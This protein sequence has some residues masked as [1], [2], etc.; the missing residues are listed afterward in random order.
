MKNNI[1]I[2]Y[3][4]SNIQRIILCMNHLKLRHVNDISCGLRK[5]ILYYPKEKKMLNVKII[6]HIRRKNQDCMTRAPTI[7]TI[8]A[9]L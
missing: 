4:K 9:F 7:T 5:S 8:I 1:Y 3:N 6:L 2:K